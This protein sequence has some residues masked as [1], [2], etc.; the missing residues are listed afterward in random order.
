MR[1]AL[2]AL[3]LVACT[4]PAPAWRCTASWYDPTVNAGHSLAGCAIADS[5]AEAARVFAA[6]LDPSAVVACAADP[7]PDVCEVAD[8]VQPQQVVPQ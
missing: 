2:L 8:D 5:D 3:V 4:D 6:G 1:V 7:S